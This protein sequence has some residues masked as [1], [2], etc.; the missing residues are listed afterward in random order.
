MYYI[1]DEDNNVTKI[2]KDC[3]DENYLKVLE[4]NYLEI[5][6]YFKNIFTHTLF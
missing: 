3:N 6:D 5:N 1:Y 2:H 4:Y